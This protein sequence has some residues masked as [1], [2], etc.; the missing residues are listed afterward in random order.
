MKTESKRTY[1]PKGY[2]SKHLE[3]NF[4]LEGVG[5]TK[6]GASYN[7]Y[8]YKMRKKVL[9][10]VISKYKIDVPSMRILDIGCGSGFYV[11]IWQQKGVTYLTGIDI[12]AISARELSAKYPNFDFYEAD[13]TSPA[14]I[15]TFPLSQRKFD[16]ITAFDILFHIVDDNK[17]EQAIKNISMLCSED[18]LVFITDVFP[19]R[20]PYIIFHQKSRALGDYVQ[21][22]SKI[23]IKIIDRIPVYYLLNAPLDISNRLIQKYLLRFWWG[24]VVR[25]VER[26]TLLVGPV[27]FALDSIFTRLFKESPST[28][29]VICKPESKAL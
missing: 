29:M 27:F 6:F 18:G 4:S 3:E 22:L 13:I 9:E 12:T 26:K 21:V 28:E 23:G 7:K 5:F 11:D 25:M 16:V 15:N 10:R 14:L 19:H 17:F 20:K 8:L 24:S 1:N 2:W